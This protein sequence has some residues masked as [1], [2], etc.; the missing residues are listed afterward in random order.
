[1][2]NVIP[3]E[4]VKVTKTPFSSPKE[5]IHK[6]CGRYHQS[7]FPDIPDY[8]MKRWVVCGYLKI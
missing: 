2:N 1:M 3:C 5:K 7:M 8:G 4:W 6:R